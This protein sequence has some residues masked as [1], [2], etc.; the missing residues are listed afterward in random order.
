MMYHRNDGPWRCGCKAD[1]CNCTPD[2]TP[3]DLPGRV[4]GAERAEPEAWMVERQKEGEWRWVGASNHEDEA[5]RF[6][7][8]E[9]RVGSPARVVP[10]YRRA[11]RIEGSEPCSTCGG[12]PHPSGLVCV[13][14]GT[15]LMHMEV[16]GLRQRLYEV[17]RA[18]QDGA[19]REILDPIA[20][21]Y[22]IEARDTR[23]RP[24]GHISDEMVD[25]MVEA[26]R[27]SAPQRAGT[28]QKEPK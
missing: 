24:V 22:L 4:L 15:G 3:H 9:R 8:D 27:A 20:V 17:E 10:L 2:S 21:K 6:A 19:L 7:Q 11:E 5:E 14:G 26:L 16:R 18:E 13:C 23:A 28:D 12:S 25:R 1:A